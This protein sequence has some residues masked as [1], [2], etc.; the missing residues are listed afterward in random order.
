MNL[1][2][3]SQSIKLVKWL[4]PYLWVQAEYN[5]GDLEGMRFPCHIEAIQPENSQI[6]ANSLANLP[7]LTD[8]QLETFRKQ[9]LIK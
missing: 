4:I 5:E 2:H 8:N 3:K 7:K 6:L 1:T 9:G